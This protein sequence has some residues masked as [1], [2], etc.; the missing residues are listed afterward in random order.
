MGEKRLRSD[1]HVDRES[2]CMFR[3][4]Y[5]D[6][7]RFRLHKHEYYELFLTVKGDIIH[8]INGKRQQLEEGSLVFIRPNDCH[9]YLCEK[10]RVYQFVNLTVSC[11]T[12]EEL[13]H[14]LGEGFPRAELCNASYPPCVILSSKDKEE[15]L[16]NLQECSAVN[17]QDKQKLKLY[18]RVLL[19]EILTKYFTTL[20]RQKDSGI[21]LWLESTCAEMKKPENFSSGN[22]RMILLAGCSR[23][24]LAR[25]MKKYYGMTI[26]GFVN[27]LRIN[28]AAN[29]LLNS[30]MPVV[31]LCY[32]CGFQSMTWFYSSFKEQ[33]HMTPA[34]YR[35]RYHRH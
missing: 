23:E 27:S 12:M 13:F 14:Y 30:D 17:W 24:H 9:D 16:K 11:E 2:G 5:S 29:M 21:P 26:S 10:G 4:I 34:Q 35:R 3:Y 8:V 7:E 1:Y 33:Y 15:L 28:Y 25:C 20:P 19:A 18:T 32:E 22:D 6:T 31:D